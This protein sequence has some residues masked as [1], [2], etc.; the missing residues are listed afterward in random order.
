MDNSKV[1]LV[2]IP[3]LFQLK[4]VMAKLKYN[5]I[6]LSMEEELTK[7]FPKNSKELTFPKVIVHRFGR[8]K[9]QEYA[10]I[11]IDDFKK[12]LERLSE[13]DREDKVSKGT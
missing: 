10:V 9:Y 7:N 13:L 12:L 6:F 8:K 1:D 2:F 3:Y 5:E 4:H 11:P